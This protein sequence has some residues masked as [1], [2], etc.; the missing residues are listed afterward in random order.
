MRQSS[1]KLMRRNWLR[2][3]LRACMILSEV[4]VR[5]PFADL[6]DKTVHAPNGVFE[7]IEGSDVCPLKP[8]GNTMSGMS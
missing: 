6:A 3:V 8:R 1:I 2:L 4:G 7:P 5:F